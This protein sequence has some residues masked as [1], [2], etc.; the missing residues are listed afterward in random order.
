MSSSTRPTLSPFKN[1]SQNLVF[2]LSW[3]V[4]ITEL[5]YGIL[6][7]MILFHLASVSCCSILAIRTLS[8]CCLLS[9]VVLCSSYNPSVIWL[10]TS[11]FTVSSTA[12]QNE[13]SISCIVF[14]IF[15]PAVCQR[16]LTSSLQ[17]QCISSV[18]L[19]ILYT[20]SL[21]PLHAAWYHMSHSSHKI[22]RSFSITALLH[23]PHFS[24]SFWLPCLVAI[25]WW[26]RDAPR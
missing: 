19:S 23:C 16:S 22:P 6:Y 17:N 1:Y 5:F 18:L 9:S 20:S 13:L 12:F 15:C 21:T 7:R 4:P 8:M 10:L 3:D 25:L 2:S 26:L 14:F 24:C 11:V